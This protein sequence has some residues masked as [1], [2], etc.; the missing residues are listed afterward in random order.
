M[1]QVDLHHL[2]EPSISE[3]GFSFIKVGVGAIWE[4]KWS[5]DKCLGGRLLPTLSC[6]LPGT[7]TVLA[8]EPEILKILRRHSL[9]VA[10]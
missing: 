9:G 8:D 6:R 10:T 3:D 1:S 2:F 7:L 5:L 4:A